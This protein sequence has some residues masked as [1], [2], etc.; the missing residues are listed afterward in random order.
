MSLSICNCVLRVRDQASQAFA[1]AEL[2]CEPRKSQMN[3]LDSVYIGHVKRAQSQPGIV[4]QDLLYIAQTSPLVPI[5]VV[6]TAGGTAGS[7]IV[8]VLTT[9]VS[10]LVTVQIQSGVSTALQIRTAVIN[11]VAAS[12]LVYCLV[13]GTSS[14]TQV[15]VSST[16]LSEDYC[17]LPLVET[18]TN[19]QNVVFSLNWDVAGINSGST[20]FD[21]ML[22]PNQ[23]FLD[24]SSILTIS[25]G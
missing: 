7:E 16:S 4:I 1:T 15:T 20:L 5:S 12:A 17:Y 8:T 23:S 22:I 11:S 9:T 19:S 6:Y 21:P 25:R 10:S 24:L 14:N 2:L 3:A 18:T 13:S